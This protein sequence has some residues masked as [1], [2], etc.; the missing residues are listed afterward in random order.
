MGHDLEIQGKDSKQEAQF[1]G[2]PRGFEIDRSKLAYC[3]NRQI[4]RQCRRFR[5]RQQL[6][7][8]FPAV[9]Y[10]VCTKDDLLTGTRGNSEFQLFR[11]LLFI[12]LRREF[13]CG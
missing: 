10:P 1:H 2:Q 4:Q 8:W 6:A 3:F 12:C 7:Y 9:A 13:I 11:D 5:N